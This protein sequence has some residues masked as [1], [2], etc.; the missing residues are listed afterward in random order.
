MSTTIPLEILSALQTPG[1]TFNN[2]RSPTKAESQP[3]LQSGVR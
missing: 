1:L 2:G 3:I